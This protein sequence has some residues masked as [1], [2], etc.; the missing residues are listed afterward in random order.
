MSANSPPS[1]APPGASAA[2]VESALARAVL[3]RFLATAW[4]PPDG[5]RDASL[6][7]QLEGVRAAAAVLAE[8]GGTSRRWLPL[9]EELAPSAGDGER[10]SREYEAVVGHTV[11]AAATPYETEWTGWA[12]Q[13][14]QYHQLSDVG[15]FYRAFGLERAADCHEREDHLA[16]ELDFMRFLALKEAL[17]LDAGPA[18]LAAAAA[19]GQ[20]KFLADHLGRWALSFCRR[21]R[22]CGGAPFYG[23]AAELL[24]ELLIHDA[25]RLGA[26]LADPTLE[27]DPAAAPAESCFSCNL[28]PD[29]GQGGSSG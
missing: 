23:L 24:E 11:R 3:Y 5:G 17:G 22:G 26:R 4:R 10:L 19:D 21:A 16:V 18:E 9:V 25:R 7:E 27:L 15:A 8:A 14:Q 20:R 1:P 29:C 12:G 2:A 28:A 6:Q 13:L